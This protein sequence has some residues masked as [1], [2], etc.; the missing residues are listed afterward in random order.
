MPSHLVQLIPTRHDNVDVSGK[1]KQTL[2]KNCSSQNQVNN[3]V[4]VA[5]IIPQKPPLPGESEKN[6]LADLIQ[7]DKATNRYIFTEIEAI[8]RGHLKPSSKLSENLDRLNLTI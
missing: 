5:W 6:A 3:F 1:L 8:N 4:K 7:V 2:R